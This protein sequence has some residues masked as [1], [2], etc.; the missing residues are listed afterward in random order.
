MKN[1]ILSLLA[2]AALVACKKSDTT[3]MNTTGDSTAMMTNDSATVGNDSTM[4]PADSAATGTNSSV[5]ANLSAQDKKFADAAARGGMME[6]MMGQL[7][8]TNAN[9]AEVKSLG[10]MMVK[11]HSKA[12]DELK[13]WAS[14]A[15]YTLP[16]SLDA[17]KQKKY[18][19]LKAKKGADFDRAYT[20]LMVSD[21]KKDI[22]EFKEEASKGTESSLKSFANKT[23]PTLEHH[24]ME[25]EKAKAAAK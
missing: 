5:T 7:A 9:S 1:S 21:H 2:V 4:M 19:D 24:L 22:A 6:V 11:D 8:S 25:S 15:G 14:T 3:T 12:N 18:D 23:V 13:Q 16:T 17:D 20:D 10:A